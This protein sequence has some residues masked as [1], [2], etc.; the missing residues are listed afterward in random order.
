MT[1]FSGSRSRIGRT[2]R[3]ASSASDSVGLKRHVSF[4]EPTNV[5]SR[6]LPFEHNIKEELISQ[7]RSDV[8][9][10]L[11]RQYE[12]TGRDNRQLALAMDN[13]VV[14]DVI[15][16]ILACNQPMSEAAPRLISI[17]TNQN[18]PSGPDGVLHFASPEHH[19]H[20]IVALHMLSITRQA[21]EQTEKVVLS[22]TLD[23]VEAAFTEDTTGVDLVVDFSSLAATGLLNRGAKLARRL[24]SESAQHRGNCRRVFF[25][26]FP[27]ELRTHCTR[28]RNELPRDF[29]RRI[30]CIDAEN[31]QQ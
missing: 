26:N 28:W 17:L 22:R 21:G 31:V 23:R 18:R 29:R 5:S 8:R 24:I 2:D 27:E 19:D 14:R 4:V 30:W 13:A 3:L 6:D 11:A 1:H 25:V 20:A 12:D 10:E 7:V 16:E 15:Q 9:R